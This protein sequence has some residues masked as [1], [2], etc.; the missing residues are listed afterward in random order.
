MDPF[1][2]L[3]AEIIIEILL[4]TSDFVGIESLLTVSPRVR[5]IF[6]SRP[7]PLFQEL[8][9]FNSITS[10]SPI[11]KIIQ[12][13]QFLHNSSF[14]FHGIEEYRQCTGSLQDQP[15]IHTDVTEVSRMMQISAQIQRLACKCLWTMQQNFISIVS[16]SPAGNLSRSIRAQKAAKPFSWVEESTIYWALWHLRHYSDLHSYGTRLNWTEESMKTIQKYQTWN[17]IDGLAPEIITTVAAVLSDLGLSPIYPPYP[18]MNEPGESIRGA[19]WWILETPPPLFKSF[20]LESMDIAIW[21]SPPTPPDDIVTAAWLLNEERCG[22]V[23]TQMGM[24]KNWARIRAFQG[25]NPDYTLLRIQPY[26]RLG[27]LL[28]DPWRMYSTGLMKWNSREPLIPAPDGDEDLVELV[29]VEDVTMQE[30]HS[31]W[32]TLA[33]VRC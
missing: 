4:F 20:D 11:Q 22:K 13:V 23:P 14:N 30:W 8:V 9:A 18:Y 5:T 26:R 7:G 25:P 24:Y 1:E 2:R 33:G 10:A 32:I 28:W 19:W 31:R 29:G 6:H 12:K 17:D 21:P 15:V 16:A 3:P 27:V